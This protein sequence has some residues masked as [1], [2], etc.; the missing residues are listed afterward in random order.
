MLRSAFDE[1]DYVAP[2]KE[3]DPMASPVKG[4][5]PT[6]SKKLQNLS[7]NINTLQGHNAN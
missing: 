4:R 6:Q 1:R 2:P 3:E 7:S 5:Y